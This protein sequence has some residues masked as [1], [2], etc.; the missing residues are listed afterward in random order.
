MGQLPK[1]NTENEN[2]ALNLKNVRQ[3]SV[4]QTATKIISDQSIYY[5]LSY[6]YWN[7]VYLAL[8]STYKPKVFSWGGRLKL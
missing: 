5:L 2:L 4:Q 6:E 1:F 7:D 8:V 3:L